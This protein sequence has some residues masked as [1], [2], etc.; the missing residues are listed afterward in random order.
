M[1]HSD[2]INDNI[3]AISTPPGFGGIA[4]V[5]VSGPDAIQ[6]VNTIFSKEISKAKGYSLHYGEI[7][8]NNHDIDQVV[9]S[10]FKSPK[11]FTGEDVVEISCHGSTYIQQEILLLLTE[12]GARIAKP[13]EFSQKAF[14][15]GK[16]D[17]TQTEAIAD[18]IH[19]KSKSAHDIALNQMKGGFANELST[20][21]TK[22]IELASLVELELDFSEED[23]EFAD[24][25]QLQ[26]L[27]E[28]IIQ[29]LEKLK[30]SF[31]YGNAIKNGVPVVILGRPNAGKSTLLNN[32][33]DD[34]RALVS[35]I[36]GTT[37][38]TIEESSIINGI[39]FKFIDT[40]GIRETK[41]KVEK[42]G[43]ERT[44]SMVEK[45]SILVYV[46]DASTT[47]LEEVEQDL[48]AFQKVAIPK[49][50]IANK[51]DLVNNVEFKQHLNISA[52]NK[53]DTE[54]VKSKVLDLF[55]SLAE[56][57]EGVILTNARHLEAI[58]LSLAD[59]SKV[60]DGLNNNASGEFIA[61]D[62]RQSLHHIGTIT[63]EISSDELLG[64]I[65]ANFCIGK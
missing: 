46:Y 31:N 51:I 9:V 32:L 26:S 37:R 14:I 21:R 20:L 65:F 2:S 44:L 55:S 5:R 29:N 53:E 60:R 15:N 17:L 56:N 49:L 50:I 11:S 25:D 43:V 10:I 1:L 40:A 28:T 45:A 57:H 33:I 52:T 19:A 13:G 36:P 4:V 35:D 63:G 41:D 3:C 30:Q 42:M 61:M 38:D 48:L 8:K 58:Q 23:V 62:I 47:T 59:L 54:K 27:I 39:E 64:N 7:I 22:L 18:L 24:R 34:D 6:I 12:N 16:M